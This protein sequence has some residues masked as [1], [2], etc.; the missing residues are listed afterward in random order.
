MNALT[1]RGTGAEV[2]WAYHQA[3]V[4]STWELKGDI[5]TAQVVR[6][7]PFKVSQRPLT[8]VVPRPKG[9]SWTWKVNTLQIA[10]TTLSASV[11]LQ[12]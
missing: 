1:F 12:E 5:L 7:D 2:R 9:S 8:F 3:A 6:H 10:G 11:S 4:L